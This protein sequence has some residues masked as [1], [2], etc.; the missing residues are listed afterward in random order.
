MIVLESVS[1]SFITS[2]KGDFV[3]ANDNI[4]LKINKGEVIGVVGKNGAGKTTLLRMI[5]GLLT[6]DSG[7]IK[8]KNKNIINSNFEF[9]NYIAYLSNNTELYEDLTPNEILN[10]IKDIYEIDKDTFDK[11]KYELYKH[12]EV[13]QYCNTPYSKLSTGQKQKVSIIRTMIVNPEI[14]ILDE[15][16]TGLDIESV[17][18]VNDFILQEKE[19]KKTILYSSHNMEEV[20]KMCDRIIMVD[21]A[22]IIYD[23][24]IKNAQKETKTKN[25]R[26][27]LFKKIEEAQNEKK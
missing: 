8:I 13:E 27:A 17:K 15:I 4:N 2:K 7:K 18:N 12:F 14:Y 26:D 20:E 3:I 22:K 9:K 23:G 11:R 25:L 16:T 6:P 19:L 24:T 21:K 5:A 1:K 10:F